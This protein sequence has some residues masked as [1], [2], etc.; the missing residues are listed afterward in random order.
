M[1]AG[2][3]TGERRLGPPIAGP[4]ALGDDP[5]RLWN[6]AGTLALSDFKLRFFGSALGYFWQ[7]LR[8]LMIFGVLY[9]VFT[10]IIRIGGAVELYPVALLLGVV[11]FTFFSEATGSA[12]TSLV[13]REALIRKVAFPRLAV[14]LASVLT[15]LMNVVLNLAAVVV[16]LLIAGGVV[17]ASWLQLPFLVAAL[18]L[19]AAG[20]GMLLS[21][22]YV[23]Y[24]DVKPIWEVALQLLFYGS[25][26]F[27]PIDAVMERSELAAKLLMLNP[28][29]AILQQ[30]RHALI[31][32]S[33]PSAAD[34]LGGPAWV[35][36]PAAIG[37]GL[38]VLGY[39]VFSRRAP[40][41]AELL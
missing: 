32:P 17:R 16:F 35:L 13:D 29:A 18:A 12:V 28:F 1:S 11:F 20:V 31:A 8:P 27:Y 19:L 26:I 39:T 15:A 14:P 10:Q 6:L 21:A 2:A 33:H 23:R 9:V 4:T 25:P 41:V 37:L 5:R 34:V 30:A 7:L 38:V 22:L 36:A 40:S 24:R 3:G